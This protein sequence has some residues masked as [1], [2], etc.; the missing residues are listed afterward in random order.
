MNNL[1]MKK[2][3]FLAGAVGLGAAGLTASCSPA[4]APVASA[5]PAPVSAR[6]GVKHRMA[7]TTPLFKSPPGF[8]NALALA[9]EGLW[10][11]EQKMS[12]E[13]AKQYGVPEPADLREAAWLVD[14]NGKLL[15]TVM[16]PSRNTSGMGFGDGYIWMG[17]NAAPEGV[18][19]VDMNGKVISHRQI[20][21]GPPDNGGGCHGV[22]YVDGKLWICALRLRGILRVDAKT[23]TPEY[24]LPVNLPETPRLHATAWDNGTIWLVTG[25]NS[26]GWAESQPGLARF[27]AK[28][29]ALIET[30]SF[31][32]KSADPHGLVMYNGSLYSCD[33]GIHPN[34]KTNDSPTTGSIFRIDFV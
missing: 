3:D 16:T 11:G 17:A 2:R 13:Q 1:S 6:P 30:V 29:G 32:P 10:I 34:W 19:Q 21:L 14:W 15:K 25:T 28:T 26:T 23:W 8:P 22:E 9:P 20:P 5:A 18:F 24:F 4:Q 33:A 7:T 31:V 12:G 27:D